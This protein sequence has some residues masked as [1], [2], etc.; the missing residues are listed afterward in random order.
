MTP[1]GSSGGAAAAIA[2]GLGPLAQGSD[3]AG[4]IRIPA[5]FCGIFGFKPSFGLVP[6][7]PA[8]AVGDLSHLGPMTRTVR[9]AALMLQAIAGADP[10]DRLSWS[11]GVD[12]LENIDAEV[13]GMRVAWSPT[14]GYAT[15]DADVLEHTQRAVA[16]FTDLGCQVDHVDP[17]LPDPADFLDV[18]WSGA[19]AGYFAN[20]LDDVRDSIDPGLLAVVERAQSLTAANLA[21]AMQQRNDYY[22]GMRQFMDGYDILLTPTLPRTAFTAGL[23]EPDGWKRSTLAPLDWTPFTYPFNLTGQPAATVPCGFD[24]DGLPIGLQ[25]V[26]R[27]REDQSVLRAAAGFESAMPWAEIT[28]PLD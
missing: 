21:H 20:R 28:P 18:M 1:G 15:V 10:R 9:D 24:R 27:W 7:Y 2:A 12:C 16:V 6:Q 3:G 13:R 25:I 11:S 8:S 26:G 4:S 22:A 5:A 14:L 23:D 19:M 17:G